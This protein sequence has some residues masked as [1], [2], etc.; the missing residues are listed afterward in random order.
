MVVLEGSVEV[1]DSIFI[2][3]LKR[4]NRL[5]SKICFQFSA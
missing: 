3:C 2:T 5:P 1:E 4:S